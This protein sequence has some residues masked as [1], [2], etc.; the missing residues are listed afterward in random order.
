MDHL[1][2][3]LEYSRSSIEVLILTK[4]EGEQTTAKLA[5]SLSNLS[6]AFDESW[7]DEF[8]HLEEIATPRPTAQTE[9]A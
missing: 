8:D 4:G 6:D 2:G 1:K 5:R 7:N 9:P 3:A